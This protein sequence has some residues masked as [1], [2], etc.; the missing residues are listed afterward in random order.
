[1]ARLVF[2]SAGRTE[3]GYAE[4]SLWRDGGWRRHL[5]DGAAQA[6]DTRVPEVTHGVELAKAVSGLPAHGTRLALDNYE[7]TVALMDAVTPGSEPLV[8]A[9]GPERGWTADDRELLHTNG[10]TLASLGHRVMRT[11]TAA[12]AAI[13]LAKARRGWL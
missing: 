9:I 1:V 8:L 6:F 2:A 7:A 12:A 13:T 10:F 11:E 5:L 3:S 4:S